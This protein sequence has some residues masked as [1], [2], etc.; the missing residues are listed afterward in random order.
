MIILIATDGK[1]S[2]INLMDVKNLIAYRTQNM[3][4]IL[5]NIN[6]ETCHKYIGIVENNQQF[7]KLIMKLIY[8]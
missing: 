2:K 6:D 8:K 1:I 3:L 5:T 7:T 4:K